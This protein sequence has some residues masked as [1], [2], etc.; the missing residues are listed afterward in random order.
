MLQIKVGGAAQGIKYVALDIAGVQMMYIRNLLG[1]R[2][3]T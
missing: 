3:F 2:D 1:A